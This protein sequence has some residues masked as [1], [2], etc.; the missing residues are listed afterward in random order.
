[1][2]TTVDKLDIQVEPLDRDTLQQRVYHQVAGL[3]LDGGIAPGQLVTIQ[4]LADSFGVSTMPVREALKRLTA[5]KALTVVS[6]R[7]MGIPL[8]T[9]ER[10]TDLRNVRLE[11]EGAA[12][13]W[14]AKGADK[15]TL[16]ALE[17]DLDRMDRAIADERRQGFPPGQP[18]LPFRRLPGIEIADAGFTDRNRLAADQSLFQS[19][20]RIGQLRRRQ[21]QSPQHGRGAR[22][23]AIPNFGAG[24][25]RRRYQRRLRRA[26]R[27]SQVIFMT[28][29]Q[30]LFV[31]RRPDRAAARRMGEHRAPRPAAQRPAAAGA[32]P[33][34]QA[35]LC[36]SALH[37]R[38]LRRHLGGAGRPPASQFVLDRLRPRPLHD[39]GG[40][41]PPRGIHL[42]FLSQ[43]HLPGPGAR[44]DRDDAEA[45]GEQTGPGSYRDHPVAGMARPDRVGGAAR[46]ASP[47]PRPGPSTSPS[48]RTCSSST[49]RRNSRRPNG[50]CISGRRGI[51]ISM[52]GSPN[53]SR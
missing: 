44:P 25:D 30:S 51:P 11:L 31:F 20:P 14:A 47:R 46:A 29:R 35:R 40:R 16:A 38:R 18:V 42:Q 19:A 48:S 9:L 5:E 8:L 21:R 45:T 23:G 32:D 37:A 39:A 3:I 17:I 22:R 7:S 50:T 26:C 12:A 10:L 15:A 43:R 52:S 41:R 53:R 6:G 4:S 1:M 27:A 13:A 49:S 2:E 28:A 34:R 33:G 24:G 36:L